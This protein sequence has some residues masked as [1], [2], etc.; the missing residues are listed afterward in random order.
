MKS[1]SKMTNS[2]SYLF[3]IIIHL[4]FILKINE[5]SGNKQKPY[6]P[7]V[8][9]IIVDDLRPEL[10]CYGI[11][12]IKSPNIDR[13]AKSG[14]VFLNSYANYPV[15]GASRAS[16]LSGIYPSQN[17]LVGWNC[18]QDN[19][20]PGIVS[21]PMYFRNNNYT[22]ISLGKVYN[23]FDD[24]KGSWDK[25]W[26]PPVENRWD[27][28]SEKGKQIFAERN[29]KRQ[30]DIKIRNINNLPQPGPA[31]ERIDVPD[32]VYE[33]GRIAIRAIEELQN[34]QNNNKPFFLA[35]GFK[36]PHLPFNAPSKYWDIYDKTNID[37]PSNYY[38]P[39]NAPN[40]ARF[41]WGELRAYH[42]I[43]NEG[44]L[45]KETAIKLIHGYYACISFVDAQIGKVLTALENLEFAENT[46]IVLLGDH[47]FF[48]GEHGFWSKHSN[49]KRGAHS[50]LIMKVP[51]KDS[52]IETNEFVEF[53]DI[54]PT[55]CELTDL[56]I[57]IHLQGKSFETLF[58]EPNKKWKDAIFYRM[59]G[60]TILTKTHSYTEWINYNSGET[61]ARMLF[62][63]RLDED[64]NFNI[65]ELDENKIL[66]KNLSEN[67]HSHIKRRDRIML[68]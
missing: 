48:L 43:P 59:D 17:R 15:C 7:N 13:L 51:W 23:N 31:Y 53:V 62:D 54:Y 11:S 29:E 37:L 41:N 47:G 10:G 42:G 38:F 55:L 5:A 68:P 21:L 25:K 58:D 27:Y 64:E 60:E 9:F 24:G 4:V 46:I 30:N 20:L 49:L 22:T 1:N 8:L 33:D 3:L 65:A 61:Y 19:D 67:L 66:I 26:T 2:N 34:L 50:P 63:H 57:P 12:N 18:S 35:V 45:D 40:E 14:L 16:I 28:Q 52:G 32:L 6:K 36:K 39:E 44:P 56:P